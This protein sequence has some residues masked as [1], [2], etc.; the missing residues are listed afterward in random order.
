MGWPLLPNPL[1]EIPGRRGGIV[2]GPD[3]PIA[4]SHCQTIPRSHPMAPMIRL[5]RPTR[6]ERA[7]SVA[8][9]ALAAALLAQTWR[10]HRLA[11]DLERVY[12]AILET[13]A[14]AAEPGAAV[15]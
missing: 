4:Y 8:C 1:P 15:G 13:P 2:P 6:R 11:G 3:R 10:A 9:L 7:L 14:P 12:R 5:A